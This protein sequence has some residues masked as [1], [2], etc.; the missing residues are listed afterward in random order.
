[1]FGEAILIHIQNLLFY[2]EL[3]IIKVKALV[4]CED[5]MSTGTFT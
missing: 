4:F 5:L 1:M 3:M 2:A